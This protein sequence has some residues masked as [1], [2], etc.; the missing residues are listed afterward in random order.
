MSRVASETEASL[1]ETVLSNYFGGGIDLRTWSPAVLAKARE[2]RKARVEL[3]LARAKLSVSNRLLAELQQS[4]QEAE[5]KVAEI[6]DMLERRSAEEKAAALRRQKERKERRRLVR[7]RAREREQQEEA[8][9]APPA[10]WDGAGAG[11]AAVS[12]PGGNGGKQGGSTARA[13]VCLPAVAVSDKDNGKAKAK[14]T[15]DIELC[16]FE[17]HGRCNDATCKFQH[18]RDVGLGA[19]DSARVGQ[20]RKRRGLGV[21]SGAAAQGGDGHEDTRAKGGEEEEEEEEE[22]GEEGKDADEESFGTFIPL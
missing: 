16:P 19:S 7:E 10:L 8:A 15:A 9:V 13:L 4:R 6:R 2:L 21:R 11:L 18:L 3:A 12:G 1:E 17:L 14:L 20:K 22:A 5:S